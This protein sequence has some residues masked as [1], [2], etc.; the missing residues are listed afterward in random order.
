MPELALQAPAWL[1]L[2]G[3]A[4]F[5]G[6]LD[7]WRATSARRRGGALVRGLALVCLALALSQPVAR[8]SGPPLPPAHVLDVSDS[9]ASDALQARVEA[10]RDARIVVVSGRETSVWRPGA[11]LDDAVAAARGPGGSLQSAVL[12]AAALSPTVVLHSD[13]GE[14]VSAPSGATLDVQPLVGRPPGWAFV[15]V[16]VPPL[17]TS[18]GATAEL[19]VTVTG[20]ADGLRGPLDVRQADDTLL[21]TQAVD[22]PAGETRTLRVAVPVPEDAAEGLLPLMLTLADD[23]AAVGLRVE[24]PPRVWLVGGQAADRRFL[25]GVLRAEGFTLE[26]LAASSPRLLSEDDRSEADLIVLVGPAA[27]PGP[28]RGAPLSA[29]F[30][31]ALD[32]W[33]RAGGG[34]VT[35]GGEFAYDQGGWHETPLAAVLPVTLD[36]EGEEEEASVTLVIALDKSNS[37]AESASGG[38]LNPAQSVGARLGRGGVSDPKIQL[39]TRAASAAIGLLQP[40]DFVGVLSVDSKA[41][42]TVPVQSA[43]RRVTIQSSVLSIGAAGGGI[44]THSALDAAR[45]ALLASDTRLRHLILF[46]DTNDAIEQKSPTTGETAVE[47]VQELTDNDV[48]VSVIGIGRSTGRDAPFLRRL[49]KEGGG[50][51]TLTDDARNLRTLFVKETEA[52]LAKGL[53]EEPSIRAV[54]VGLHPALQGVVWSQAPALRG[55]NRVLRRPGARTL[56][57]GPDDR[58]LLATRVLGRGQVASWT[59]DASGRWASRW[60]RWPGAV[61]LWT[62]LLRSHARRADAAGQVTLELHDRALTI[63]ARG[64]DGLSKGIL[65]LSVQAEPLQGGPASTLPV[66][67]VAPGQ[68]RAPLALEPGQTARLVVRAGGEELGSLPVLGPPSAERLLADPTALPA[69]VA[70]P[71]PSAPTSTPLWRWLLVLAAVL[72]PLDA[73]LRRRAR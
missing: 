52:V 49:A 48:T 36:P 1:A 30:V 11:P 29:A 40:T 47:V 39:V 45:T 57:V 35:V 46:A 14:P 16:P 62:Q 13:G 37:M 19:A 4:L 73:L 5:V 12:A 6:V 58:P 7:A 59:S 20:G 8:W 71:A 60:A 64:D 34:L 66:R 55:M 68:W 3:I 43:A 23:T 17:P 72:L 51:F 54:Q 24:R 32:P 69:A 26:E 31:A 56:L 15:D 18:P 70:V 63:T 50:R 9:V 65:D 38:G 10:L 41:K 25:A 2:L 44:Y 53:T 67:L 27:Q 42:W 61:R 21:T 22:V 28:G 33:V